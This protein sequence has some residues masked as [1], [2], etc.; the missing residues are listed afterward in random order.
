MGASTSCMDKSGLCISRKAG[1]PEHSECSSKFS[2]L[3]TTILNKHH[4]EVGGTAA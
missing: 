1:F 4:D 3:H 2:S